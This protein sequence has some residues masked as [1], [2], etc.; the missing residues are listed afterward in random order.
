MKEIVVLS[1][2]GGTGKTSMV[3][4][5]ASLSDGMVLA[6]CD[7]DAADLHLLLNPRIAMRNDFSG[8]KKAFIHEDRC[9]SCDRCIDVCRFAAINYHNH[10]VAGN[11]ALPMI[12]PIFCEGCGVCFRICPA[13]AIS[14]DAVTCGEW[15]IST[16][17]HGP[18]VHARLGYGEANS[19]KL[20]A[21]VREQ[22]RTIAERDR[23]QYIL[24]DGPPGTGCPV[25]AS[26][27]GSDLVLV[28]TE[29]TMSGEHDL[30]RV[31]DLAEYFSIP[32]VVCINKW[33][34]NPEITAR[35]EDLARQ[36]T[37][38]I[39]GKVR[40]DPAFVKA[41]IM[42]SSIIEYTGGM[43]ADEVR[44]VWRNVMYALP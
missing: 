35:I 7:V 4:A 33:D 20:A 13:G 17:P 38:G 6:D 1:G 2:K 34:I 37:R 41:Q 24:V 9:I 36:R 15:Y 43:V 10:A 39:A 44:S 30:R 32:V 21:I 22:A 28:I 26:M 23:L 18:M 19:G 16:A 29:P 27:T 11:A 12:N 5:F 31:L 42:K 8:G 40:Y 3:A 25:I 14:F